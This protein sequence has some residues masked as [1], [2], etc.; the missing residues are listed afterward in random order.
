[1]FYK[2]CEGSYILLDFSQLYLLLLQFALFRFIG[3]L[4]LFV[5]R[6]RDTRSIITDDDLNIL[7]LGLLLE[8][9]EFEFTKESLSKSVNNCRNRS[10]LVLTSCAFTS[11]LTATGST[12]PLPSANVRGILMVSSSV[13]VRESNCF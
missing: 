2:R 3:I 12:S 4:E 10:E 11:A 8:I 13:V 7:I 9:L 1:M 6:S 5:V